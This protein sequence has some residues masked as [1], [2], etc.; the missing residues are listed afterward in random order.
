MECPNCKEKYEF[1]EVPI[2]YRNMKFLI[3]EFL[4]PF[5]EVWI[6]PSN[7]YKKT[8][9]IVFSLAT[10]SIIFVALSVYYDPEFKIFAIGSGVASFITFVLSYKILNYE[11]IKKI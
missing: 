2:E 1:Y 11:I 5:C 9:A 7:T 8:L 6:T 3:T 10:I 4:C